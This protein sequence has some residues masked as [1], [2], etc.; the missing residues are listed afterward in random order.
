[1]VRHQQTRDKDLIESPTVTFTLHSS[2]YKVQVQTPLMVPSQMY[3]RRRSCSVLS[4]FGLFTLSLLKS[5][6]FDSF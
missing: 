3:A 2:K 5:T 1:M 6:R 4:R